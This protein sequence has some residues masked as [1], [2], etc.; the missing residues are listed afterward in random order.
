MTW[1]F[2]HGDLIGSFL[3]LD[4][5]LI[6]ELGLFMH[7]EVGV[8]RALRSLLVRYSLATALPRQSDPSE[9]TEN[10]Y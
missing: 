7:D 3:K 10:G 9:A 2:S 5:L 6:D 4:D 8:Q 1:Q